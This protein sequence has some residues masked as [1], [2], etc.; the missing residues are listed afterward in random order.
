[1]NLTP[2]PAGSGGTIVRVWL[3]IDNNAATGNRGTDTTCTADNGVLGA[4]FVIVFGPGED[5]SVRAR[6]QRY[7]GP[8]CNDFVVA[9]YTAPGTVMVDSS[10]ARV[11][12]P[13]AM[14][15]ND[16]G[17]FA[18][19]V[20]TSRALGTGLTTAVL[21]RMTNPGLPPGLVPNP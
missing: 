6:V 19:K 8:S 2:R 10:S 15:G 7:A 3:D 1:V 14:L 21:D 13:L 18:F 12:V 9:G 16:D 17:R 5:G 4:D 20:T 11:V